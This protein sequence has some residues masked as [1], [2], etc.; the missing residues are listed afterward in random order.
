LKFNTNKKYTKF[1]W[2]PYQV[3]FVKNGAKSKL[4]LELDKRIM[5]KS[6]F[7]VSIESF[8]KVASPLM[9]LVENAKKYMFIVN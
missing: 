9:Y 1:I 2:L 4:L 6:I 8:K 5:N 7:N 3:I